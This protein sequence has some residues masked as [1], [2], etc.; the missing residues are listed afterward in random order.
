MT[1]LLKSWK[2]HSLSCDCGVPASAI[3][4]NVL[5]IVEAMDANGDIIR[6]DMSHDN[7]GQE[8]D[9][10]KVLELCEWA[11]MIN[12]APHLASM[13]ADYLNMDEEDGGSPSL[14]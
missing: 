2:K 9:I 12:A 7:C 6:I 13:V 10:S 4:V 14:I 8:L 1:L 11:K 5:K 3:V